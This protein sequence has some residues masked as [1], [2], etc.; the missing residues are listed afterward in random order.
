VQVQLG[1]ANASFDGTTLASLVDG[2]SMV[3]SNAKRARTAV[4]ESFQLIGMF[5][6]KALVVEVESRASVV[7]MSLMS[8]D[9]DVLEEENASR[10]QGAMVTKAN[11]KAVVNHLNYE[12]WYTVLD[13]NMPKDIT[14]CTRTSKMKF[15]FLSAQAIKDIIDSKVRLKADRAAHAAIA[16]NRRR[17]KSSASRGGSSKSKKGKG[18]VMKALYDIRRWGFKE[19]HLEDTVEGGRMH[20]DV[21]PVEVVFVKANNPPFPLLSVNL[22]G[23]KIAVPIDDETLCHAAAMFLAKEAPMFL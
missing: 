3:A 9:A 13:D 17:A 18:T 23:V 12:Y 2:N 16:P 21:D 19:G 11:H 15:E 5:N 20:I 8:E 22:L 4:R 1:P 7:L 10:K 14:I 6:E